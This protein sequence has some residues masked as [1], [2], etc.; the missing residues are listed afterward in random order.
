MSPWFLRGLLVLAPG[1]PDGC[2]RALFVAVRPGQGLA[3][4]A[5]EYRG[6]LRAVRSGS[7]EWVSE[8]VPEAR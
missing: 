4:R 1:T 3:I 8:S 7:A 2:D 6:D 5:A